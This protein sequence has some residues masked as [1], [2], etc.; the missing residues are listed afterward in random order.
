MVN[1]RNS[2]LWARVGYYYCTICSKTVTESWKD[3]TYSHKSMFGCQK[4]WRLQPLFTYVQNC[5]KIIKKVFLYKT[6]IYDFIIRPWFFMHSVVI[7]I[8][9]A[10]KLFSL[11]ETHTKHVSSPTTTAQWRKN[12]PS[13]FFKI[14][15]QV[16]SQC[17]LLLQS[18]HL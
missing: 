3:L 7:H 1:W 16:M 15:P 14:F 2:L 17:R 13:F 11:S 8:S 18:I 12:F 9:S 4:T 6:T 5:K 10:L